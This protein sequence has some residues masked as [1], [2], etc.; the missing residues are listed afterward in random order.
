[1]DA[2]ELK[3][4]TKKASEELK[5]GNDETIS[6]AI[7]AGVAA[8]LQHAADQAEIAENEDETEE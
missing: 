4:A 5:T 7:L 3:Q 8:L 6:L 1:M 2:Y